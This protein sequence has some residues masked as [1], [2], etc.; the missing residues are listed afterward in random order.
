MSN[1]DER[2]KLLVERVERLEEERKGIGEDIRDVFAEMKAVG[3]DP[4]IV[5]KVIKL[6]K[7]QDDARRE[8]D[9][10]LDTYCGALGMQL[11]LPLGVSS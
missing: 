10:L 9:A 7:M 11:D 8:M 1:I 5:R 4:K 6:R 3:Y 2:L